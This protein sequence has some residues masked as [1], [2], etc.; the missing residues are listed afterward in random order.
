M[1]KIDL[2]GSG[3]DS[4]G[5]QPTEEVVDDKGQSFQRSSIFSRPKANDST[6]LTD[7]SDSLSVGDANL[8]QWANEYYLSGG[9]SGNGVS[10]YRP[11]DHESAGDEQG[12]GPL[13]YSGGGNGNGSEGSKGGGGG[14]V[15]GAQGRS[16]NA[17][18]SR[19]SR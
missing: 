17:A 8:L 3:H 11:D 6:S 2:R 5:Y 14:Q 15:V 18:S 4:T 10:G 9:G 1:T 19:G 12:G 16:G 7:R 13:A